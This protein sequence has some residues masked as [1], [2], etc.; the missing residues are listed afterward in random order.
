[1]GG[2]RGWGNDCAASCAVAVAAA[3]KDIRTWYH[4]LTMHRVLGFHSPRDTQ[5]THLPPR[6]SALPHTWR[7]TW[8]IHPTHTVCLPPPTPPANLPQVW[9]CVDKDL[10]PFTCDSHQKDTCTEVSIPPLPKRNKTTASAAAASGRKAARAALVKAALLAEDAAAGGQDDFDALNRQLAATRAAA[11]AAV[12]DGVVELAARSQEAEPERVQTPDQLAEQRELDS[13]F[14]SLTASRQAAADMLL[15]LL[16]AGGT[17]EAGSGSDVAVNTQ[18]PE[19]LV[20]PVVAAPGDVVALGAEALA[21]AEAEVEADGGDAADDSV[22][23]FLAGAHK[24]LRGA[25]A[26]AA[27]SL[28]AGAAASEQQQQRLAAV[29]QLAAAVAAAGA[30]ERVSNAGESYA[31]TGAAGAA[32]QAEAEAA[33]EV[34]AEAQAAAEAEAAELDVVSGGEEEEDEYLAGNMYVDWLPMAATTHAAAAASSSAEAVV[35]ATL[36]AAASI[37]SALA[38]Q[39]VELATGAAAAGASAG[40]GAEVAVGE[41]NQWDAWQREQ[42]AHAT[43]LVQLAAARQAVVAAQH[44]QQLQADVL[45]GVLGALASRVGSLMQHLQQVTAASEGAAA[46]AAADDEYEAEGTFAK[47]SSMQAPREIDGLGLGGF[48]WTSRLRAEAHAAAAAAAA[49]MQEAE[50][51]AAAA[52]NGAAAAAQQQQRSAAN[53]AAVHGHSAGGA[54]N[55][56][57]VAADGDGHLTWVVQH[58]VVLRGGAEAGG[59]GAGRSGSALDWVAMGQMLCATVLAVSLALLALLALA[60]AVQTEQDEPAAVQRERQQAA[61]AGG[62]PVSWLLRGRRQ[63]AAAAGAGS[64]LAAPLLLAE[65][66]GKAVAAASEEEERVRGCGETLLRAGIIVVMPVEGSSGQQQQQPHPYAATH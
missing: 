14:G 32:V 17:S 61:A 28:A 60:R 50:A 24:L 9:M 10:K 51:E 64:E 6:S 57:S 19:L 66:A 43:E 2:G 21:E 33:Q 34:S 46:V 52:A 3:A 58:V 36:S 35:S 56:V 55:R 5:Q 40:A 13:L 29:Q 15:P 62:C 45:S 37:V 48:V 25:V 39:E 47:D 11:A 27:E 49:A 16:S 12:S 31:T 4:S 8:H 53:A 1:M 38:N 59:E 30:E 7:D 63:R 54:A 65:E 41:G 20:D 26:A 44:A 42:E 18:E 23:A 22:F